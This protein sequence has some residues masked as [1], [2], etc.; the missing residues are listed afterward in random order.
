MDQV[1]TAIVG[2]T[3]ALEAS[4]AAIRSVATQLEAEFDRIYCSV[5][6]P[7]STA[8]NPARL[9]A[10]IT[11]LDAAVPAA[12]DAVLE[13]AHTNLE[14]VRAARAAAIDAKEHV[15]HLVQDLAQ[16]RPA[17][18][19]STNA[20]TRQ[21]WNS[22][23]ANGDVGDDDNAGD[24]DGEVERLE[25][26]CERLKTFVS[27]SQR[28]HNALVAS[29][30][31]TNSLLSID[32]LD[33]ELL[34]SGVASSS[35]STSPSDQNENRAIAGT[36]TNKKIVRS[37]SRRTPSKIARTSNGPATSKAHCSKQTSNKTPHPK[38]ENTLQ[39]SDASDSSP[40]AFT[41]I[42]KGAYQRLPRSLKLQAKLEDLN[43]L[44]AKV[45]NVLPA[46]GNPISDAEL[47]EATG[48]SS[49][50]RLDVLR[51]GFSVL[52]HSNAGWSR[53]S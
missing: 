15:V 35:A 2:V 19:G 7:A 14:A 38:A 12:A 37:I 30:T 41:P 22:R 8:V 1:E 26:L 18:G 48:E 52:K 44:Y 16:L 29:Q 47:L 20:Q 32:D 45:H 21:I 25:R 4:Q 31:S 50:H 10:R 51:R 40:A 3:A 27:E 46:R 39:G 13:L 5:R 53:R 23:R 9:A 33:M 28:A 24:D 6:G 11:A 17:D 43:E 49:L 42:S 34:K 36:P